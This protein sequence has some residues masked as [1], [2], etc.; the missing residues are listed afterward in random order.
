ME[1]IGPA[2]K[3][4]TS[5]EIRVPGAVVRAVKAA[6]IIGICAVIFTLVG[7]LSIH[8]AR[9]SDPVYRFMI[10]HAP[11]LLNPY[12]VVNTE[13]LSLVVL[14][15]ILVAKLL[16]SKSVSIGVKAMGVIGFLVVAP[17]VLLAPGSLYQKADMSY[18]R[19]M[20]AMK[21]MSY[22]TAA[23]SFRD[24]L[25]LNLYPVDAA[26]DHPELQLGLSL[27]QLKKTDQARENFDHLLY[28]YRS[29]D[30]MKGWAC[31]GIAQCDV[32]EGDYATARNNVAR[33]IGFGLA[34]EGAAALVAINNKSR[35]KR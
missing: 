10:E 16:L 9:F 2:A 15:L 21:N 26:K 33:A 27:V 7:A 1:D 20:W 14:V 6:Q 35:E 31:L 24:V 34:D 19:G 13:I 12:A 17:Q 11:Y 25:S 4:M 29:N 18:Q 30:K 28:L 23:S 8:L 22:G 3:K 5:R 32:A